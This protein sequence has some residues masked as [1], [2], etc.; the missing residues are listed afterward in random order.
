MATKDSPTKEEIKAVRVKAGKTQK[1]AGELVY[2][3][4]NHWQ[5]WEYGQKPMPPA[6]FELFLIKTGQHD[7]YH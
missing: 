5:F 7:T 4:E 6:S 2:T 3:T 1:E